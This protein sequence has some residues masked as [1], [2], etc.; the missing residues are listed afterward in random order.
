MKFKDDFA[1]KHTA[2]MLGIVYDSDGIPRNLEGKVLPACMVYGKERLCC[3]KE[4]SCIDCWDR[5]I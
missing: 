3:S 2:K 1:D 4:I 5:E